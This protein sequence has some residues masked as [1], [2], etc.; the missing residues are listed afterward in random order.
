MIST[1]I[2]VGSNIEPEKNCYAARDIL[3]AE[4]C[5][6]AD[7]SYIVTKPWGYTDQ[8]D[9]LNGAFWIETELNYEKFNAYLK[10]VEQRLDRIKHGNK[11]GPR[12][13]DLDIIIWDNVIID[14]DFYS[15][16]Y[17]KTP[18]VELIETHLLDIQ[19]YPN[20]LDN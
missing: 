15:K 6:K 2:S 18:V 12:T 7:S 3:M 9:F 1:I 17:I 13:I 16:A 14:D 10:E 20:K 8:A 19:G 11:A 5:F 4:T